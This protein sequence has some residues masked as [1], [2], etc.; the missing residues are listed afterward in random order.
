MFGLGWFAPKF[1]LPLRLAAPWNV[2]QSRKNSPLPPP[3]WHPPPHT[4]MGET[5]LYIPF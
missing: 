4:G 5:G 2:V 3:F 1:P